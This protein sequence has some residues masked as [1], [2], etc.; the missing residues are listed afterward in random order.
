MLEQV[1]NLLQLYEN[2]ID[3][4][5]Y[6]IVIIGINIL[7]QNSSFSQEVNELLKNKRVQVVFNKELIDSMTIKNTFQSY[8]NTILITTGIFSDILNE[9]IQILNEYTDSELIIPVNSVLKLKYSTGKK[10]YFT[11]GAIAGSIVG[12]VI[13]AAIISSN[14]NSTGSSSNSGVIDIPDTDTDFY[15]ILGAIAGIGVCTA[16]GGLIGHQLKTDK[17]EEI[18]LD[19]I[20]GGLKPPGR[21]YPILRFQFSLRK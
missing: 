4:K 17:W 19:S 16:I 12:I 11:H 18:P 6:L 13:G 14:S 1:S 3:M 7:I 8:N 5:K 2:G 15:A 10:S 21:Y 9:N 20:R